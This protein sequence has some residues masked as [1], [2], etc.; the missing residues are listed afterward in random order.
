[1]AKLHVVDPR[2]ETRVPFLRGI[3]TRSLQDAGLPFT[4]AYELA[5]HVRDE[6]SVDAEITSLDLRARVATLLRERYGADVEK[7]YRDAH[8][9][10][11][12]TILV[13]NGDGQ[14][15]PFSRGRHKEFLLAS[16]LGVQ[17]VDAVTN[18]IYEHL[19]RMNVRAIPT[20]RLSYLTWLTLKKMLGA[21]AAERYLVWFRFVHSGKPLLILIGGTVGCGKSTMAT[22]L[23]HRLD[24]VRIQ[25]TDMLREVM[26]V[27]LAERL[28]PILHHS[29]F[30]A[31]RALPFA[32]EPTASLET[33]I[34]EGY[35]SQAE[36][37][38][39]A[40][41]AVLNRARTEKVALILE[42]V[43]IQPAFGEALRGV[44]DAV[45]IPVVLAVLKQKELRKRIQG[46]GVLAPR[47]RARRY[48]KEFDAIWRLQSFLLSEADR[49][50]VP[51]VSNIDK[52]KAAS[53]ILRVVIDRLRGEYSGQPRAIFGIAPAGRRGKAGGERRSRRAAARQR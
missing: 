17:E 24:I 12:A 44:D 1:M 9:A 4:D 48:L 2:D 43:H 32:D 40:G 5:S 42:G 33:L 3:L 10:A 38:A 16:G 31:W 27:M 29:S 49:F 20:C 26:R 7:L 6:L 15:T 8:R 50:D 18:R 25:S 19:L 22:T 35:Q 52:D 46:R 28:L 45:V 53:E 36:L 13:E 11:P 37:L 51:I 41:D 47:R 30:N 34:A 39:V 21:D 23:A 14:L